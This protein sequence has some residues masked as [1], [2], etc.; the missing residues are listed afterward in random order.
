MK[1]ILEEYER[2]IEE[3]L[4][5]KKKL[6][7]SYEEMLVILQKARTSLSVIISDALKTDSSELFYRQLLQTAGTLDTCIQNL[8]KKIKQQEKGK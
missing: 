5:V 2:E 8:E 6:S 4:L 7:L 1:R 3:H